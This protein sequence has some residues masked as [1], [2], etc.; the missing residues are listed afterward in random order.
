M[1]LLAMKHLL[2]ELSTTHAMNANVRVGI[3]FSGNLLKRPI[4]AAVEEN[5]LLFVNQ[6]N[7]LFLGTP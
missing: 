4:S 2:D 7:I 6:E 3:S 5:I 1:L